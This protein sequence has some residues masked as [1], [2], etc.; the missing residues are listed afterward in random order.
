MHDW[1]TLLAVA[2]QDAPPES[3][4]V[5][6]YQDWADRIA[7]DWKTVMAKVQ[8]IPGLTEDQLAAVADALKLREQQLVDYLTSETAAIKD[9]QHELWRLAEMRA[10]PEARVPYMQERIAA[11]SAELRGVP[12]KWVD[13]VAEFEQNY[14]DDLRSVLTD[15]QRNDAAVA[16]TLDEALTDPRAARLAATNKAVTILTMAVGVCLL[17]GFFTRLASLAGAAFLLAIMATQPPW[18]P[19]AVTTFFYY[20]CVE[21]VSLLVLAAVGAGRWLGLDSFS[22]AL[23]HRLLGSDES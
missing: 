15:P 21:L 20:Q 19:D 3:S 9:Y 13:Q 8:E 10:A 1:P 2:R 11:K 23:W 12:T 17:L 16:A 7:G 18:A 4:A 5:A 22:Y 14:Y 6:P